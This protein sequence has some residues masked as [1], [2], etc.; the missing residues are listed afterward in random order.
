MLSIS[1]KQ[2]VDTIK[3]TQNM[4]GYLVMIKTKLDKN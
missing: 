1:Q 3:I 2:C 4:N